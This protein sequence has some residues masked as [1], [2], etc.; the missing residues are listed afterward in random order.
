[1]QGDAL[2]R[3]LFTDALKAAMEALRQHIELVG[4]STE[5]APNAGESTLRSFF[6]AELMHREPH[7]RC[8]TEWTNKRYDLVVTT[9][10]SSYIVEFKFYG[11][12]REYE[13]DGKSARHWKGYPSKKNAAEFVRCI[14]KLQEVKDADIAGRFVILVYQRGR[15]G[16]WKRA[17]T[18]ESTY[19]DLEEFGLN[20][21]STVAHSWQD[22]LSC[23]LIEDIAVTGRLRLRFAGQRHPLLLTPAI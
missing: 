20:R 8:Q 3:E 1:V 10:Q 12:C 21:V 13:L 16:D 7:A 23:K 22:H 9:G 2:I 14:T 15:P 6:L 11:Y 19:D 18:Y 4:L 5:D 17:Y